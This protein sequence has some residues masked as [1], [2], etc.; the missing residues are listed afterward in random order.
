M[1]LAQKTFPNNQ[2]LGDAVKTFFEAVIIPRC[3]DNMSARPG[4][5]RSRPS[6]A[7][8][9]AYNRKGMMRKDGTRPSLNLNASD[10]ESEKEITPD[11][12]KRMRELLSKRDDLDYE[13]DFE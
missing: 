7:V 2:F 8:G 3:S 6:S 13:E 11:D 4:S 10:V 9:E 1:R 5:A 12:M